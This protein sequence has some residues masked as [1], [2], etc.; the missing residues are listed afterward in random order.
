MINIDEISVPADCETQSLP[1]FAKTSGLTRWI[2][3]RLTLDCEGGGVAVWINR[4]SAPHFVKYVFLTPP[5]T[6]PTDELVAAYQNAGFDMSNFR[7]V[8]ESMEEHPEIAQEVSNRFFK[9]ANPLI[10]SETEID[11]MEFQRAMA[12]AKAFRGGSEQLLGVN[13]EIRVVHQDGNDF[14]DD[15]TFSNGNNNRELA[16]DLAILGEL[17]EN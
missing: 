3:V 2:Y 16:Y 14:G 4:P 13:S 12:L 7:K 5:L 6:V 11:E 10:D 8:R 17:W 9:Q 15:S 1:F